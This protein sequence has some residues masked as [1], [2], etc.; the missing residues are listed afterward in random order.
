MAGTAALVAVGGGLVAAPEGQAAGVTWESC[1]TSEQAL[2]CATVLVPRQYRTGASSKPEVALT[3]MKRPADDSSRPRLGTLFVNPGGPGLSPVNMVRRIAPNAAEQFGEQVAARFDIV[4]VDPRGVGDT[5]EALRCGDDLT[6]DQIYLAA[7][8]PIGSTKLLHQSC[9]SRFGSAVDEYSTI[10][11]ARDLDVVRRAIGEPTL[12]F[13]GTSYGSSVASTYAALFPGTVRALVIDSPWLP[14]VSTT[15]SYLLSDVGGFERALPKYAAWCRSDSTC[16]SVMGDDPLKTWRSVRDQ[17][18]SRSIPLQE[19]TAAT[20]VNARTL[21]F[22]TMWSLYRDVDWPDLAPAIA[23]IQRSSPDG[24]ALLELAIGYFGRS[25]DGDWGR[26]P[27]GTLI[28]SCATGLRSR[29]AP[30]DRVAALKRIRKVMPNFGTVFTIEDLEPP[31]GSLSRAGDLVS[32]FSPKGI[33]LILGGTDDPV[34]SFAMA[35]RLDSRFT[36]QHSLVSVNSKAHVQRRVPCATALIES[37]V[38][39]GRLPATGTKC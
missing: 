19:G 1:G 5:G 25:P 23:A 27:Q 13:Y 37:V 30:T 3:V 21:V 17:L 10:T 7:A 29:T 12:T 31:C 33:T 36:G 9:S 20:S 6:L 22:A 14:D 34:T 28:I 4:G 11:V 16:R 38:V 35:Q 26:S 15:E 8:P 2:Q 39:S 32:R 24:S 18:A